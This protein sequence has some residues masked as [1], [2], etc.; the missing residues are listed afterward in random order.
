MAVFWGGEGRP[1]VLEINLGGFVAF[2]WEG[3]PSDKNNVWG[4]FVC[5]FWEGRLVTRFGCLALMIGEIALLNW[6]SNSLTSVNWENGRGD[7]GEDG[8]GTEGR[9][10][11]ACVVVAGW[12]PP[13]TGK[14]RS[15][16][17]GLNLLVAGVLTVG[18]LSSGVKLAGFFTAAATFLSSPSLCLVFT[19]TLLLLFTSFLLPTI[20]SY[21]KEE[22][23]GF[24]A[25]FLLFPDNSLPEDS[26]TLPDSSFL[27]SSVFLPLPVA[28]FLLLII[29]GR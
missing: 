2:C 23:L 9:K 17:K 18:A 22:I 15:L 7:S 5:V 3:G 25:P 26:L 1:L 14:V 12:W 11:V 21:V 16:K 6:A 28:S 13:A 19:F 10:V 4:E 24:P 27:Q 29:A 8:R 20:L